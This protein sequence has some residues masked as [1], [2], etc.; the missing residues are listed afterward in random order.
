[1]QASYD[2][3][4]ERWIQVRWAD[5]SSG[6]CSI[7]GAF[8]QAHEI[9]SL[10]GEVATQAAA[11]LRFLLAI[12]H[13]AAPLPVEDDVGAWESLWSR[14]RLDADP[15]KEYL[16]RYRDRFDLLHPSA[17]F[18]QVADLTTAKGEYASL[19]R[20]VPDVPAGHQFF[21]TRTL[22]S[23]DTMPLDEA[24][25]WILHAQAFDPSGIKSGALGDD[26]V[27]NGKG[28][29]IGVAWCG[30]LGLI[31]AEGSTLFE[32]LLLNFGP[33]DH[34]YSS[35]SAVWERPPQTAAVDSRR[36]L[37]VD[38]PAGVADLF[39]WQS[40]RIRLR[41]EN[42]LATGVLLCNGDDLA[43]VNMQRYEPMTA[44]RQSAP[45]AKKLGVT[46][47]LMPRAHRF[48]WA[49]WRGLAGLLGMSASEAGPSGE[50]PENLR[51]L[52]RL[53]VDEV[54]P[55]QWVVRTRAVG[56]E[57]GVQSA[58]I[59]DVYDDTVDLRAAVLASHELKLLALGA[60]ADADKAA[61]AL[62]GLAGNLAL[63][64]GGPPD[65]PRSKARELLYDA[66]D[67]RFRTWLRQVTEPSECYA[68][69]QDWQR[70]V[71]RVSWQL[72]RMLIDEAGEPAW[73]G[74]SVR[75]GSAERPMNTS[76]A[77]AFFRADLRKSLP[78]AVVDTKEETA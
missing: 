49:I 78:L 4:S 33:S 16:N 5:G 24:A 62:G 75:L 14:G 40:R 43:P 10:D 12:L 57:Y 60:V 54:L 6:R 15:I 25:R 41:V 48:D 26:R 3:T 72:A 7:E 74:R 29:P 38:C 22:A 39:T 63:A 28:Y 51:W 53:S 34:D 58:V 17:P 8:E 47:A 56:M 31:I 65:G 18:Y 21:T 13:R 69:L 11:V 67:P 2:L 73:L 1:M 27:R 35:D 30:W 66:L 68:M 19:S 23:L 32:T 45:Q 46:K 50:G 64:A 42:G 59:T 70:Q 76:L 77:E 37:G 52:S 71:W 44:W 9:R 36:S 20:L 61:R 55:P